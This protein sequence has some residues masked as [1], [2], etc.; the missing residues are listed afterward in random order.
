MG[1]ISGGVE[2]TGGL[3]IEG[4]GT[5]NPLKTPGV[6]V[7]NVDGVASQG[8]LTIA[9][10]VT[11]TNTF[12]IGTT[13]YKMMT[14]PA[15]AYDVAIGASEAATKVN[16]VAAINASGTP[17]TEYFAGT[18]IHPDV[19]AT[20]FSGD[21]CVLTAKATGVA[22][23][24]IATTETFTHASNIFD[25]V[26]LGTTTAGVDNVDGSYLNR[27]P[28]DGFVYDITNDDLYENTGTS[29]KPVYGKI[30]A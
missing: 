30:D 8:T 23:D 18:L 13:V 14:T 22:G 15:A 17:G 3:P 9:E 10:P 19:A 25:D 24:L 20:A 4:V 16:I 7:D 28:A 12:T 29:A 11:S 6:P 5:R 27:I 26:T 2:L 1:I 21:A